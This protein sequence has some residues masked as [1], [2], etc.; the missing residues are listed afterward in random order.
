MRRLRIT[1]LLGVV[2]LTT[3]LAGCSLQDI[4]SNKNSYILT[5]WDVK[6]V[7][8]EDN[9]NPSEDNLE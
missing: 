5:P 9:S 7:Q 4:N 3:L 6:E 1:S 8:V 2:V